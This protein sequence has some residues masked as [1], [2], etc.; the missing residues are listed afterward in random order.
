MAPRRAGAAVAA[1]AAIAW[2]LVTGIEDV[3]WDALAACVAAYAFAASAVL[4]AGARPTQLA[5]VPMLWLLPPALVPLSVAAAVAARALAD[6]MF[7]FHSPRRLLTV[8]TD[9]AA[10]FAPAV[11]FAVLGP[12]WQTALIALAAQC[13]YTAATSAPPVVMAVDALLLPLAVVLAQ[14]GPAA[15]LA[16]VPLSL[17]LTALARDRA[18]QRAGAAA[19][20]GELE[21]ARRRVALANR[22]V[23]RAL[24]A[25]D[26][27]AVV[28][29]ALATAADA[30]DAGMGRGRLTDEPRALVVETAPRQLGA[31]QSA[32]LERAER[33]ALAGTAAAVSEDGWH[34]LARP[35]TLWRDG[36]RSTVGALAVCRAGRA[37][38]EEDEGRFAELT[39]QTAAALQRLEPHAP[40]R[41]RQVSA[42]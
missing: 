27:L 14:A 6:V 5:L 39:A 37:F 22:R 20:G 17:L 23:G 2:P 15:V 12:S 30:T 21:R 31:P 36:T 42:R 3:P 29:I 38:G 4:H 41:M 33:N 35:L 32:A 25:G 16:V 1:V 10:A 7:R 34:A 18:R 9:A 11:V 28:E 26:R 24:D 40:A 13:V 19:I 8:T